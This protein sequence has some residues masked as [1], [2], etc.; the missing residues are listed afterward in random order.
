MS[1]K[2]NALRAAGLAV[3]V[4]TGLTLASCADSPETPKAATPASDTPAANATFND[5]AARN[6]H[7]DINTVLHNPHGTEEELLQYATPQFVSQL[8]KEYGGFS[9]DEIHATFIERSQYWEHDEPVDETIQNARDNGTTATSERVL[10]TK[11][12]NYA[13]A[14][15]ND[16]CLIQDSWVKENGTWKLD[17]VDDTDCD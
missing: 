17:F 5:E 15:E 9:F 6:I 16:V 7:A 2:T 13:K 8:G 10:A 11:N 1:I 12:Y 14:P 3:A 4:A